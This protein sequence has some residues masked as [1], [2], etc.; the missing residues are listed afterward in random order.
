LSSRT[1]RQLDGIID[2]RGNGH[3]IE[4]EQL[5][6]ADAK[7]VHDFAMGAPGPTRVSLIRSRGRRATV[8]FRSI[9]GQRAIAVIGEDST[10]R[11]QRLRQVQPAR[12]Q[13]PDG[14]VRGKP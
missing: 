7:D 10:G 1:A 9:R 14:F 8:R 2:H 12:A 5:V 13:A 4:M 3:P 11:C 6:A